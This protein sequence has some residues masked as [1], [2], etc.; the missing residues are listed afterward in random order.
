M[1]SLHTLQML[2]ASLHTLQVAMVSLHTLQMV[3]A[4]RRH[5]LILDLIDMAHAQARQTRTRHAPTTTPTLPTCTRPPFVLTTSPVLALER[6][7]QEKQTLLGGKD[8]E[9]G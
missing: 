7:E 3:M 6:F 1:V 8:G 5:E 9:D 4:M 2:L